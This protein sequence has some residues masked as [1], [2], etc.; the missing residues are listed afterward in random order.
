MQP[1]P[2]GFGHPGVLRKEHPQQN[3]LPLASVPAPCS[4]RVGQGTLTRSHGP[5]IAVQGPLVFPPLGQ[6][7]EEKHRSKGDSGSCFR[8]H[9]PLLA[10]P[11]PYKPRILHTTTSFAFEGSSFFAIHPTNFTDHSPWLLPFPSDTLEATTE[12]K[13]ENEG[14]PSSHLQNRW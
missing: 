11:L 2:P 9:T 5:L 14:P 13:R 3:H 10:V 7:C 12:G 6:P 1:R 4:P 8:K